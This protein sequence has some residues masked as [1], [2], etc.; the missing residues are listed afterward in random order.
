M[1]SPFVSPQD[2]SQIKDGWLFVQSLRQAAFLGLRYVVQMVDQ[3]VSLC[4]V[5]IKV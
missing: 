5:I 2:P 4:K 3:E 1:K